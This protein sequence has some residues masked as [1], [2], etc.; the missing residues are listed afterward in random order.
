[1]AS[2]MI[3]VIKISTILYESEKFIIWSQCYLKN[4]HYGH[5]AINDHTVRHHF[6]S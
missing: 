1:M 5:E 6:D 4:I 3:A 2:S